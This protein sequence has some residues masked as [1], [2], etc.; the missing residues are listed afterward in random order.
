MEISDY[1]DAPAFFTPL[2]PNVETDKQLSFSCGSLRVKCLPA[3]KLVQLGCGC[4]I[5]QS[6]GQS[7]DGT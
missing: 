3:N 6:P 7:R 1:D 4:G 5:P 2:R